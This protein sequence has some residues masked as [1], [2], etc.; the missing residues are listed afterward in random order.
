MSD[1][2]RRETEAAISSCVNDLTNRLL[3]VEVSVANTERVVGDLAST[4]EGIKTQQVQIQETLSKLA[5]DLN[6]S[7][8]APS[9]GAAAGYASSNSFSSGPSIWAKR[10]EC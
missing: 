10:T 3:G 4:V 5:R 7:R 6:T 8:S 9:L 2:N 1:N